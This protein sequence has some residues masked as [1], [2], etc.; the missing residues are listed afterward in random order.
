MV[1]H[2]IEHGGAGGKKRRIFVLVARGSG[3]PQF[4]WGAEIHH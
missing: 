3:N 4:M 2:I 1:S